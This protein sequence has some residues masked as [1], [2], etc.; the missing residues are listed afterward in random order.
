MLGGSINVNSE[1]GKGSRF[2][3]HLPLTIA[4][5]PTEPTQNIDATPSQLPH[6]PGV[7]VLI[8][9]DSEENCLLLEALLANMHISSRVLHS[10]KNIVSDYRDYHPHLVFMDIR[11]PD[12]DGFTAL[13]LLQNAE[14]PNIPLIFISA[15]VFG[16]SIKNIRETGALAYIS[17]PFTEQ[18]LI[19]VLHTS[20]H[21]H[22][23]IEGPSTAADIGADLSS[24][25]LS[26]ELA[27]EHND[28]I[29]SLSEALEAGDMAQLIATIKDIGKGNQTLALALTSLANSYAY[30]E[31]SLIF[32][33]AK[34]LKENTP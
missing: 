6:Y 14:G 16:E 33:Q 9:D 31:L 21:E 7:R 15:S 19:N 28:L 17:K 8:V 26:A 32:K 34:S 4:T 2:T 10:A 24:D 1:L 30:H 18:E 13:K 11:M 3:V 25:I 12:I 5:A 29:Q 22:V 23:F 20:L 27:Q